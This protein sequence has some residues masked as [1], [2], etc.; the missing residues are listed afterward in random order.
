[1]ANSRELQT[2]AGEV[3]LRIPKLRQQTFETAIIEGCRECSVE[4]ALIHNITF[5]KVLRAAEQARPDV[6]VPPDSLRL[7]ESGTCSSSAL[8]STR[9]QSPSLPYGSKQSPACAS[10]QPPRPALN[11]PAKLARYICARNTQHGY[12]HALGCRRDCRKW[13]NKGFNRRKKSAGLP[14]ETL[15]PAESSAAKSAP[16][17]SRVAEHQLV[18]QVP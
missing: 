16:E 15:L 4:G 18:A 10:R 6:A 12:R 11:P 1:V 9:C 14:G 8:L 3:R 2:K 5:K 7:D 17:V 13:P